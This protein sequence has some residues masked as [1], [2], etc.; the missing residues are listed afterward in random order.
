MSITDLYPDY[1]ATYPLD[2]LRQTEYSSLDEQD[3]VYLD[4]TGSGLASRSQHAHHAS[5]LSS[6]VFGNPHST[7]PTSS[8]ATEAI[9]LTRLRVLSHLSASEDEYTVIFTANATGAARLVG[10]S[11]PFS[12]STGLV[13]TADNHNSVNGIRELARVKGAKTRYVPITTP[14]LRVETTEVVSALSSKR[15]RRKLLSLASGSWKGVKRLFG[16]C[17]KSGSSSFSSSSTSSSSFPS[18]ATSKIKHYRDDSGSQFSEKKIM[19]VIATES[20]EN[21][22]Q[23]R[24]KAKGLFAFPAQSNFTGVQHPLSWVP[25]AQEQGYDVLL[26]AAAFLPTSTLD[27]SAIKPEFVIASFYKIFG[28][29]TGVGC[30]VAKK[31]ALA[32]LKRPWFAGGTVQ[33]VTVSMSW[34][35]MAPDEQAFE[36]GTV[37]FWSIPDVAFGLDF[38]DSVGLGLISARVKYLAGWF[39]WRLQGLKHSDGR[40]MVRVYGPADPNNLV[41]RGG[42]VAFN[43][44]DAQGRV[45][46]E[47][48]VGTEAAAARISLRTGCFCNPGAGEAALGLDA[49]AIKKLAR[50]KQLTGGV[51]EFIKLLGLPSAGAIRVSFG[52]ASTVEDVNRFFEFAEL[53]KDRVVSSDGLPPRG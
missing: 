17:F 31:E 32:R 29:P 51:D 11:Y 41:M 37:N 38:I 49:A 24:R 14:D 6:T 44:L 23:T 4:Y 1:P 25:L 16:S 35:S 45:V 18:P 5:R 27:L 26:D 39:L 43:F 28:Y 53:Y 48:I 8:A 13:A 46:D 22:T 19:T 52:I 50:T 10:E 2:S 9:H 30:L 47:R 34:H 36:D 40:P 3:H 33:A 42:T 20:N 12:R 21:K 7:N 15:K